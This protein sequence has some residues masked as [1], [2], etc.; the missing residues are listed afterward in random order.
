VSQSS[1]VI[2]RR[3]LFG[4]RYTA[5]EY[6]SKYAFPVGAKCQACGAPPITRVIVMAPLSEMRR[7]NGALDA[8]ASCSPQSLV[9]Q[10]VQIDEGDG[11]PKPYLRVS[12][13]YACKQCSPALEREAAKAP[14]W[15]IVEIN[16][17]PG[18]DKVVTSG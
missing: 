18:P 6:H 15:C 9:E 17:G 3:K 4:G 16:R 13:V 7:R 5:E 12:V 2:H 11:T 10:L 14:S 1:S 8:L